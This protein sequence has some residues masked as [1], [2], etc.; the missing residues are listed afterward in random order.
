MNGKPSIGIFVRKQSDANVVTT[1][2]AVK[3]ELTALQPTLLPGHHAHGGKRRHARSSIPRSMR[4][5]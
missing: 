2:N 3:E 1:A 5:G 4:P